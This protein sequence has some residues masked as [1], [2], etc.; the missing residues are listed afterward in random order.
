MFLFYLIHPENSSPISNFILFLEFR[1]TFLPFFYMMMPG[2]K[3]AKTVRACTIRVLTLGPAKH[4]KAAIYAV[5]PRISNVYRIAGA[6]LQRSN[7]QASARVQRCKNL[8]SAKHEV[9]NIQW[10]FVLHRPKRS[11]D[12]SNLHSKSADFEYFHRYQVI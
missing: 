9:Q 7:S 8:G 6:V 5:N 11:V 12:S 1:F 4:E 3:G 10:M 2:S